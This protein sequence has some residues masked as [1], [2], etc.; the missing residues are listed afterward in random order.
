MRDNEWHLWV[1]K[2][3][4]HTQKFESFLELG[5]AGGRL[6]NIVMPAKYVGVD[7]TMSEAATHVMSTDEFFERN[8]DTFDMIFVDA[9]H[10]Y[11][12][13]RK[14]LMSSMQILNEHGIIACHDTQPASEMDLSVAYCLDSYRLTQEDWEGWDQLTM[15]RRPGLTLLSRRRKWPWF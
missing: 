11:E 3:L 9:D 5:V 13:A 6:K 10:R 1:L 7:T 4:F 12:Q 8:Q 14:D 2:I 15:R